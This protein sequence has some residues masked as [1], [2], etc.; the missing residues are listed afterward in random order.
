[1][2]C[3]H[4]GL[5]G[6][7]NCVDSETVICDPYSNHLFDLDGSKDFRNLTE[8][9]KISTYLT[10]IFDLLEEEDIIKNKVAYINS[11]IPQ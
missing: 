7:K 6:F 8:L 2:A 3:K 1:L 11:F 5:D 4:Y 10:K 9:A